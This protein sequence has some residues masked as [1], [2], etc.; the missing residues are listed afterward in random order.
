MKKANETTYS[1]AYLDYVCE[2]EK[3]MPVVTEQ[4]LALLAEWPN[5]KL[6]YLRD[7]YVKPAYRKQGFGRQF[8]ELACYH[9]EAIDYTGVIVSISPSA[10]GSHDSLQAAFNCGFKLKSASENAIWLVKEI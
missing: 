1:E 2:R 5:E 3:L 4:G 6:V 10:V 7:V 8:V 9:A